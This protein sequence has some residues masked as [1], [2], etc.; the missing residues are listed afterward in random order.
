MNKGIALKIMPQGLIN[1]KRNALDGY[2]YFGFKRKA[3]KDYKRFY[4]N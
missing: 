1:S 4:Y 2:T 3:E